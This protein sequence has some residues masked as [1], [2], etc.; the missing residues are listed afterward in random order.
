V[1]E[2]LWFERKRKKR[3]GKEKEGFRNRGSVR[4]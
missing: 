2:N 4:E 3:N 1:E